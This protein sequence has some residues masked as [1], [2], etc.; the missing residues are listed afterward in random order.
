M[1]DATIGALLGHAGHTITRR[2][3]HSADA[4]LLAAADKVAAETGRLMAACL[5][6]ESV[7]P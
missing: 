7:T 6:R 5:R 1:A 3:I 4:A 2:Y